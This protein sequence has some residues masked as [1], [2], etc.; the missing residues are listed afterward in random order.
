M[1]RLRPR[2]YLTVEAALHLEVSCDS[3]GRIFTVTEMSGSGSSAGL[4]ARLRLPVAFEV[5]ALDG[6]VGTI[7]EATR[8]ADAG[9]LVVGTG[10]S[11]FGKTVL[12]PVAVV[13]RV[14]VNEEK[15]FVERTKAEIEHAPR[16]DDVG[17]PDTN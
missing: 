4:P 14:D 10:R 7:D 3:R 1:F 11:I 8:L 15:V 9:L 17:D 13:T 6:G 5:E 16:F 12:L 2:R